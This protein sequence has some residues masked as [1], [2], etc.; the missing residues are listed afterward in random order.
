MLF[1]G[2]DR[3][4]DY[5]AVEVGMPEDGIYTYLEPAQGTIP[6]KVPATIS[7]ADLNNYNFVTREHTDGLTVRKD[8]LNEKHWTQIQVYKYANELTDPE[9]DKKYQ[10]EDAPNG[11]KAV[12]GSQFVLYK[13]VLDEVTDGAT[14]TFDAGAAAAETGGYSVVGNYT[15][16]TMTDKDGNPVDGWFATDILEAADNVVYWLYETKAAPGYKITEGQNPVLFHSNTTA[17]VNGSATDPDATAVYIKDTVTEYMKPNDPLTGPGNIHA[18]RIRLN[19]W[20]ADQENGKEVYKPLGNVTFEIWLTDK[21]GSLLYQVDRVTTGLENEGDDNEVLTA[22]AVSFLYYEWIREDY[23]RDVLN[24][25][26]EEEDDDEE[27]AEKNAKIASA[28]LDAGIAEVVGED[29]IV[30]MALREVSAPAG[31]NLDVTPHYMEVVFDKAALD[32]GEEGAQDTTVMNDAYFIEEG[33]NPKLSDD[34]DVTAGIYWASNENKVRLV[35]RPVDNY[36][37]TISKYGYEP[38]NGVNTK[39]TAEELD[40]Y[41]EK[42]YAGRQPLAG[43]TMTL[44]RLD[45]GDPSTDED[46]TWKEYDYIN[47][48]YLGKKEGGKATFTTQNSGSYSFPNGLVSGQ[49]RVIEN[50]DSTGSA[51]Y[52]SLY[53]TAETAR[54]FTVTDENLHISMYN[55]KKVSLSIKKEDMKGGAVSGWSFTLNPVNGKGTKVT[56]QTN[57]SGEA[58]FTAIDSGTYYLTE[59]GSGYSI[60]FLSKYLTGIAGQDGVSADIAKFVPSG[61]GIELGITTGI[62][63]GEPM[64][65]A[66]KELSDYGFDGALTVKNPKLGSLTIQKKDAKNADTT[67]G[68]EGTEFTI[69][70]KLFTSMT[71]SAVIGAGNLNTSSLP[72]GWKFYKTVSNRR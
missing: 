20:A 41:F 32:N 71:D 23:A 53:G 47:L 22:Q 3:N 7:K 46:D 38:E 28:L 12:N 56:K 48:C 50:G 11:R 45:T 44:E 31:Y 29:I 67:T 25:A 51:G 72:D 34:E 40:G 70:R 4:L 35:N 18:A 43:V 39:M 2:L 58:E 30:R 36:A 69:Y 52:E 6:E 49:Y 37:V 1:D 17:Y 27:K 65:T 66:V 16:G 42:N 57:G 13:Q 54:Y 14:L 24:I 63:D 9:A 33:D 21:N 55:P 60:S 8:M 61:A 62:K 59:S 26:I 19:K 10:D 15:S 68:F 5:I 64:V